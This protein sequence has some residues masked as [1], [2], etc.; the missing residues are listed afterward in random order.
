MT[1]V[2]TMRRF[3]A[4]TQSDTDVSSSP[5]DAD[6]AMSLVVSSPPKAAR[7]RTTLGAASRST[8]SRLF[9]DEEDEEDHTGHVKP[10][11]F[12]P[13]DLNLEL[14]EETGG[15]NNGQYRQQ[16]LSQRKRHA[17]QALVGRDLSFDEMD[18]H[19]SVDTNMYASPRKSQL[20]NKSPAPHLTLSYKSPSAY[21]TMDGRT[22]VSHNPF[23]PMHTEETDPSNIHQP[24][25]DS[26]SFPVSF[27]E[28]KKEKDCTYVN[29]SLPSVAPLLRHRLHKRESLLDSPTSRSVSYHFNSF[30]RDGYPSQSGQYSFTGSPIQEMDNTTTMH[31][32]ATSQKVR[33]LKKGDDVMV[34]FS[35]QQA[36]DNN[37]W[38][39]QDLNVNTTTNS[40]YKNISNDEISP[41]DVM[42]F[43]AVMTMTASSPVPPTPTK[44][45]RS[46]AARYAPVRKAIVPHTPMP[47]RRRGGAQSLNEDKNESSTLSSNNTQQQSRFYSD[48][49]VIGELGKGSFGSVYKVLSRLD[50]CMYAV[51]AAHR[52]AKGN[53]DKDRMLKEVCGI[54][55]LQEIHFGDWSFLFLYLFFLTLIVLCLFFQ[56]YA[57]SSLSDQADTATFHIV[58]YHQAWMEENRLYIQTELCTST[59]SDEMR[60]QNVL[61]EQRQYKFLREILLALEFIHRNGMVHLGKLNSSVSCIACIIISY[62]TA[63]L[64][65]NPHS[66]VLF[67]LCDRSRILFL[68]TVSVI[69]I[70]PE[71]IFVSVVLC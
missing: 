25:S 64:S 37:Q 62:T 45:A 54:V 55:F 38:K 70:K 21:L 49:D 51:K 67:V 20:C 9:A 32:T 42:S 56:V 12:K 26:L 46:R 61:T 36:R 66:I 50:G 43:P 71:N 52:P 13:L 2:K 58:R 8:A 15:R 19:S 10:N 7:S 29:S 35:N 17:D 44:P 33:R 5:M 59:L 68:Y 47:D 69:D 23:S 39:R 3:S 28:E 27:G 41:S 18:S 40:F 14:A 11:I 60:K 31:S 22:V 16:H 4:G 65:W 63:Y 53:A 34:A 30:T 1:P 24:L 57:L 6:D 48:F